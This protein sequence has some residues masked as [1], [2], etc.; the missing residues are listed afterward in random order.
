MSPIVSVLIPSYN[1]KNTLLPCID[2]L[3]AQTLPA[4]RFEVIV[5][6]DG[7]T[8]GSRAALES[9]RTDFKMKIVEQKQQGK[10]T[11][12]NRGVELADGEYI[13]I[14]DSDILVVEKFLEAHIQAHDKGDVVI[15][16]IP[17]SPASPKNFMTDNVRL[18][19]ENHAREMTTH[20]NALSS[21]NIYGANLSIPRAL[22]KKLGGYRTDLRRTEDFHFGEKIIR[23]GLKVY[24]CPEAIAAQI[25]D[26]T[27][28]AWCE[29]FYRDGKSQIGL[30]E[31]F[32]YLK[33][34]LKLGRY[35]PQ[36]IAKRLVRPLVIYDHLIGKGLVALGKI[37]L[38]W[39]R[40]S[41]R[42]WRFLSD[43]QGLLGDAIYWKGVYDA[44]GDQNR[45]MQFIQPSA[46]FEENTN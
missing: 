24:Y 38:E 13:V 23:A 30:I 16:P 27:F 5:V 40:K 31:E 20:P 9:M 6:L 32:P 25:Y 14:V 44:L 46:A 17:L 28:P 29:D 37:G 42:R 43:I 18:W 41:G 11:A 2:H 1:S 45:F 3:A 33:H 22:F 10:A 4:D 21:T 19:A 15:G 39:A 36:S 26:K 12:L 7:S 8:D 35:H 34:R